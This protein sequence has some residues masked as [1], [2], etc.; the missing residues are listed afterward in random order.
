VISKK[1]ESSK[2]PDRGKE[3]KKHEDR[4]HKVAGQFGE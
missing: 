3:E 1:D 2:K 4:D